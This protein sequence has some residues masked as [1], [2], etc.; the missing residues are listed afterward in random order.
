MRTNLE[1]FYEPRKVLNR[2]SS[3]G[4][5]AEMSERQSGFLCGLIKEFKPKRILEI[6]VAAGGTTAI[7]LNYISMLGLETSIVSIDVSVD[8]YRDTN[9]KT[10]YLAEECKTL[11][12]REL[13]HTLYAGKTT[14]EVIEHIGRNFDFV[15]LDTVHSLPGELL[16]FL[17]VYPMLIPGGVIVMHDILLNHFC[18]KTDKSAPKLLFDTVVAEKILDI[19]DDGCINN[20]GAFVI[21]DDTDRYIENVF[22]ALAMTWNYVPDGKLLELYREHYR[23]YYDSDMMT[24]YDVAV[25]LN[26]RNQ[27]N[28]LMSFIK[29]YRWI[30][31][32]K[33]RNIYIYGYG[34]LG[35][36]LCSMLRSCGIHVA[37]YI[38]SDGQKISA[39]DE[40]CVQ[41]LSEIAYDKD[42]DI[43]LI[44]V[45]CELQMEICVNLS[46]HGINEYILPGDDV[47]RY[48]VGKQ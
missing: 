45:R 26:K 17:V 7:M 30:E 36:R 1:L 21:N 48:I 39:C 10:G 38:V 28:D 24:L 4:W 5:G 37:G 18:E 42:R 46:E 34:I 13:E 20:I 29:V 40:D 8:Y 35:R 3:K 11:L 31:E 19:D 14:V 25:K 16:D 32:V 12:D 41:Y 6:G 2:L 23:K 33:Y 43:I 15:I 22:S 9:K 44:G 47:L 27:Y